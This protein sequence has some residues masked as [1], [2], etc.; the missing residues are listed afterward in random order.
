MVMLT[1]TG[2]YKDRS[3]LEVKV[4]RGNLLLCREMSG[5]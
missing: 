4:K 2:H 1:E 3:R 5:A